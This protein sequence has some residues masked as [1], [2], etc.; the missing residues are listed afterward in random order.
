MA[1]ELVLD[2]EELRHVQSI[3]KRPR[4]VSLISSQISSLEK[5]FRQDHCSATPQDLTPISTTTTLVSNLELKYIM[6][7]SFSWDQDNE[8]VKIYVSFE[9]VD[10]EKIEAEF[11]PMSINI[12][13]HEVQGNNYCCAIPNLNMEI[14]P[15]KCKVLVEPTRVIVTLFKASE[16]SWLDLYFKEDK[17]GILNQGS[18]NNESEYRVD[19]TDSFT[20]DM[21]FKSRESLIEWA[22][23]IGK[24]NG[25][26]VII[27]SS[28]P[29][30]N[31]RK[32][33]IKFS[34][35]RSGTYR[36]FVKN[37]EGRGQKRSNNTG[38]KKCN[39]PFLLHGVKLA[40]GDDWTVKVICGEHNHP[41]EQRIEGHSYA[42]RLSMDE[43]DLLVDMSKNS[44]KP[45]D[46]LNV[47]KERDGR[48]ASTMKTIYNARHKFK[49]AEKA[50]RLQMVEFHDEDESGISD[51]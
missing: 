26:V 43:V 32:P 41:V 7:G 17:E 14:V 2:L 8:M 40:T 31:G 37:P 24:Q 27:K 36:K 25:I 3:V 42:G 5:L 39:C 9:G 6:L 23:D 45:K 44:F 4:I 12:K 22:R 28:D 35:E 16:G 15:E 34:C 21:V 18:N 19:N 1:D 29:G 38:S 20:T 10:Q 13:F 11:K 30:G 46:I 47:L 50:R 51:P 49:V 33:R 48:N